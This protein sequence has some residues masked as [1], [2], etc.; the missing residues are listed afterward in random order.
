[1]R[2]VVTTWGAILGLV[3]TLVLGST[4]VFGGEDVPDVGLLSPVYA[5]PA[6]R[7]AVRTLSQG[8]TVGE[9]LLTAM[10]ANDQYALLLAL[11]EQA[12]PRR[13]RPGTEISFHWLPEKGGVDEALRAVDI[14]LNRDETV[15]LRR[16]ASG[17][18]SDK[19]LTPVH[20]DTV[21][22]SG[23]INGSLWNSMESDDELQSL[24]AADRA[25]LITHLAEIYRWQVDF[26]LEI[27]NGDYWRIVYE[28]EARPDGTTRAGRILSAELVNRRRSFTAIYFDPDGEGRGTYYDLD[29]ESVKAMFLRSPIAIS[30]RLS[31]RFSNSRFHPILKRWRAHRGVDFGG[32]AEGTPIQATGIGTIQKREWSNSYGNWIEIRHANGYT[33]RYAHMSRFRGG[34]G[35]G[36]AVSQ[37]QTI[38]YVGQTGLARGAHVHYEMRQR[39]EPLDPLSLDQGGDPVPTDQ[40]ASW[41]VQRSDRFSLLESRVPRPW[42]VELILEVHSDNAQSEQE[43][44]D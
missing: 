24:D 15:R 35:V 12:S 1:L 36:S 27:R 38:G 5:R 14:T 33:T 22:A 17:W 4:F 8:E 13:M 40:R 30:Y 32:V 23:E 26:I 10:D 31:S 28:R 21:F 3:A 20:S 16:G 19:I 11:R 2:S 25:R 41:E 34:L 29:G 18:A 37:G 7:V 39:G 42:E 44:S 43:G 9:I 6:E